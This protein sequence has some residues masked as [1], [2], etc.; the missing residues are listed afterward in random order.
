MGLKNSVGPFVGLGM[1]LGFLFTIEFFI[2]DPYMEVSPGVSTT[3]ADRPARVIACLFVAVHE[4]AEAR[5]L[6]GT[7]SFSHGLGLR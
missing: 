2:H 7:Y 4:H 5:G 3:P 6:H 1:L